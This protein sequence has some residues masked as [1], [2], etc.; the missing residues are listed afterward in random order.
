M[1]TAN[2]AIHAGADGIS[3]LSDALG[4]DEMRIMGAVRLIGGAMIGLAVLVVVLNEVW[5]LD[6]IGNSSGNFTSVTESLEN[7]GGA[8]LGLLVIGLLVVAANYVMGFFGS[9]GF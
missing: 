3:A 5:S 9:G 1:A 2:N 8:A 6:I 7:T 4:V